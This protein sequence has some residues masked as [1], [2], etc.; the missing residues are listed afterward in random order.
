MKRYLSLL[1]LALFSVYTLWAE[2]TLTAKVQ[3]GNTVEVGSQIRVEFVLNADGER[4]NCDIASSGLT[5][6]A[7]PSSSFYSSQQIINGRVTSSVTNTYTY[8]LRAEAEGTYTIPAATVVSEGKTYTSNPLTIKAIPADPSKSNK[9]S[10]ASQAQPRQQQQN[11]GNVSKEDVL[12]VLDL[13]KTSIYEGEPLTATLKLYFRNQN[14][15]SLSDAKF[16]DFEG[17]TSQDIDLGNDV[18]ATLE[19]YRGQ[20]YRMYPVHQWLLFPL[21]SGEISIKP[22]SLSAVIQVVRAS[23]DFWDP[24][25]SYQ[26]VSMPLSTIERTINVKPLPA[27]KPASY[28]NAVGDY[29][30]KSELTAD[31]VRANDAVIYRITIEGTGNLRNV[32][33]P[34][35]EFHPD[36]E[37]YDPKSDIT[38]RTGRNGISGKKV[39]EYTIIPRF[40]GTFEIPAVEFSYFDPKSGQYRTLHTSSHTLYVEK[41]A[42]DGGAGQGNSESRNYTAPVQE[43]VRDIDSDI[44]YIHEIPVSSLSAQEE[45]MFGSLLYWMLILVPLAILIALVLINRRQIRKNA[46]IIGQ[47]N[48][49]ANKVASRRLKEASAAL[50]KRNE[51][52][53]YESVHKAMLGY[54]SDKLNIPQSELTSDSINEAFNARDID[55]DL[56]RDFNDVLQQCEFA[57]Y[58]PSAD[59]QAMDNLYER[60]AETIGQLDKKL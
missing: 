44:R 40:G 2:T 33:D 30:I 47:R 7:G 39:I 43:A 8:I 52:A 49:K 41:G 31:S 13:S 17:F 59:S 48:R 35:P 51:N 56:A 50:R 11:S 54:V 46:D 1:L 45:P 21:H 34:Q 12:L 37:V 18:Q 32:R 6:L 57:R 38:S 60:A 10:S 28:M 22:A 42:N 19:Q 5:H 9:N 58:A 55:Q 24:F 14:V 4:I 53:F 36:F 27:G 16:P 3:G 26:N 29:S 23:R 20:N 15:S 25:G